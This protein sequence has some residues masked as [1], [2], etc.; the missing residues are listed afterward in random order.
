MEKALTNKI[1]KLQILLEEAQMGDQINELKNQLE[2]EKSLRLEAIQKQTIAE[3]LVQALSTE[4]DELTVSVATMKE[5]EESGRKALQRVQELE[6]ELDSVM[7][8]LDANKAEQRRLEVKSTADALDA[9]VLKAQID[10]QRDVI[11]SLSADLSSLRGSSAQESEERQQLRTEAEKMR[12][13]LPSLRSA[14]EKAQEDR[15]RAEQQRAEA[16]RDADRK[17]QVMQTQLEEMQVAHNRS[18]VVA[19]ETAAELGGFRQDVEMQ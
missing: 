15:M 18:V 10:Q 19:T 9:T 12:A 3:G 7:K 2:S 6:K 4:K 8:D 5:S 14:L 17:I 13:E 11:D 16:E 1:A